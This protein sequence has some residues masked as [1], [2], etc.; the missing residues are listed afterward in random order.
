MNRAPL[1][2]TPELLTVTAVVELATGV[3]LLF[4]PG[5]VGSVLLGIAGTELTNLFARCFGVALIAL[6]IACWPKPVTSAAVRAMWV[7]NGAIAL[8]L[9]YI[10]A[11]INSGPL[12][13]P[14]VAFHAVMTFLLLRR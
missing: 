13:W 7:Y 5:L 6:G 9:A 3:A 10:G 8:Y 2:T 11:F 4:I 1:V 12:L 14:A